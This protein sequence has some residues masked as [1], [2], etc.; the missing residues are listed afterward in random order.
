[1][2]YGPL[3]TEQREMI[4]QYLS[5][6]QSAGEIL[7]HLAQFVDDDGEIS[8]DMMN[9][10]HVGDMRQ[11]AGMLRQAKQFITKGEIT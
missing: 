4:K 7:E 11:F 9:W 6:L 1:M 8:P 10:G 3:D 5:H 2:S